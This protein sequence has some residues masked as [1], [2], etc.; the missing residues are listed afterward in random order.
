LEK[1]YA[2][3]Y[4]G[5][6]RIETGTVEGA[7]ADIGNGYPMKISLQDPYVKEQQVS[8]EFWAQLRRYLDNDYCLGVRALRG[9][10]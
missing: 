5:Y 1:A 8:G 10:D 9:S 2:K 4:S 6:P 7:L 3:L